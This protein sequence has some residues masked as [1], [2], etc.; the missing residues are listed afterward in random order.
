MADTAKILEILSEGDNLTLKQFAELSGKSYTTIRGLVAE[1]R[2]IRSEIVGKGGR[3]SPKYSIP[4]TE[5]ER[6]VAAPRIMGRPRKSDVS[7]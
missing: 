2:Q 5:L 7:Y 6:F 3:N 4:A 1:S